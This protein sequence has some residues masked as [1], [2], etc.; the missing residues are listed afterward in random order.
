MI[1]DCKEYL[2]YDYDLEK[3]SFLFLV[4]PLK[5]LLSFKE[6]ESMIPGESSSNLKSKGDIIFLYMG[7]IFM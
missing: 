2:S 3:S 5:L 4:N 7:I 1:N 6:I